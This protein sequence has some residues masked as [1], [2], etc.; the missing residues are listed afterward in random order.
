[1]SQQ[2]VPTRLCAYSPTTRHWF[3]LV[4]AAIT[5]RESRLAKILR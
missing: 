1:M 3:L 4:F 2:F 5:D